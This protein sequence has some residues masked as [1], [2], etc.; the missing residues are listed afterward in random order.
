MANIDAHRTAVAVAHS[1]FQSSLA[2]AA[3]EAARIAAHK[4]LYQDILASGHLNGVSTG[5]KAAL[6]ARGV[7]QQALDGNI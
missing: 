7:D 3:N 1:K 5:A 2:T 6:A 4:Q